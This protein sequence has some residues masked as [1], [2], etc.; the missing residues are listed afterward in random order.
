MG[1]DE[2]ALDL[3]GTR[4]SSLVGGIGE[5][6]AWKYL[7]SRKIWAHRIG[8]WYPF[9][10][11]YPFRSGEPSYEL[12]GLN[13]RQVEYLKEMWLHGPRRYDFVGVRR[14]RGRHG[15]VGEVEEVYLVEVKTTGP[16]SGRQALQGCMRGKIPE[17]V[18]AA[19]AL[20]FSVLLVG[21]RLLGD[22][23]C[24]VACREL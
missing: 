1:E 19:K 18:E 20:G 14:R 9:P 22:W 8:G 4:D 12:R 24:E 10:S 17:D 23:R 11:D 21:V 5:M 16:G 7:R 13:D 3:A 15:L 6:I 2:W